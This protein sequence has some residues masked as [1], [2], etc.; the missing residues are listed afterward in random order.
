MQLKTN[1]VQ[2][3]ILYWNC[4]AGLNSKIDSIRLIINKFKPE[5]FFVSEAEVKENTVNWFQ[6]QD[7]N[8]ILSPTIAHGLSR[9]VCYLS[10]SSNLRHRPDL[11]KDDTLEMIALDSPD[12]YRILGTYR[13][14]KLIANSTKISSLT[15]FMEHLEKLGTTARKLIIGGDFNV[16]LRKKSHEG[17]LLQDWKDK[18]ALKQFI[19]KTT[20]SRIVT[21]NKAKTIRTSLIDH[22]Y[23]SENNLGVKVDDKWTSDHHLIIV[24]IN[25]LM[26]F[27]RTKTT[28]RCWKKYSPLAA[29]NYA[30][31]LSRELDTDLNM[32][33]VND[34]SDKLT[35]IHKSIMAKL[36]PT[37]II[38]TSRSDDIATDNV[39]RIKKKR[40]RKL[41]KFNKIQDTSLLNEIAALDVKLKRTITSER[42]QVIQTKLKSGNAKA[43]WDTISRL[44]GEKDPQTSPILKTDSGTISDSKIVADTFADFF[45]NKVSTLSEGEAPYQWIRSNDTITITPSDVKKAVAL[46]KRKMCS[47]HDEIPLKIIK[48]VTPGL[49]DLTLKLM[50]LAAREIPRSWKVSIIKPLHKNK[51]K[52]DCKNYRPISNIV[53]I[54]KVFERIVLD[55]LESQ[56]YNLEGQHQHGFRK[57]R[58]TITALLDLQNHIAGSLDRNLLTSV[59]SVDM[60]A[61]FDLLRPS[62][63]HQQVPL[64][65]SLMN[66]V[67]DFMSGRKMRVQ[68]GNA[69]ST[70]RDVNVGCVQGSILGP[71]LFGIYCSKLPTIFPLNTSVISYADD[72]Y[73]INSSTNIHDLKELTEWCFT[74]HKE[75]LQG[76][77]MIVNDSKTELL[78]ASRNKDLTLN[79]KCGTQIVNSKTTLKALGVQIS[80]DLNWEKHVKYAI[81]KSRQAVRRIKYIK[82]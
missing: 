17:Y 23:S 5:A 53:S 8:L 10:N 69:A 25:R 44:Q 56:H 36:C 72:S 50:E 29:Q 78:F 80:E 64:P 4:C 67:M 57:G 1:Q 3:T 14:F 38:R 41:A 60:T 9:I 7:Y 46:L 34:L 31:E 49:M 61:A 6:I 51:D 75:Y 33:N 2:S 55:K 43:F 11:I 59:Y 58:S 77:G 45:E 70:D 16:N 22:V 74:T 82:K 66:I 32:I 47:G 76:I 28:A 19:T 15:S 79:I 63:F 12:N 65:N 52:T 71:K 37:R 81:N 35:E 13:P 26:T 21:T 27:K 48:D 40:K 42:K 73:V 30:Q 39:E 54:S 20:W 18:L 24:E 68:I 62:V